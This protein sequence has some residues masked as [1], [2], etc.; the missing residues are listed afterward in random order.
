MQYRIS[1][2]SNVSA[3]SFGDEVI[4]ANFV[5]GVYYSLL[6]PAAQIWEGLVA[7]VPLDRV[8]AEVSALSDAEPAAFAAATTSLV[9]ALLA[10]GLLVEG[11]PAEE[12]A[13]Q[14][15]AG[16]E[17]Q[18]GLP[19][20]ERFTDMEDLLLLDPVHDVEEMGWPHVNPNAAN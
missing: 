7:G 5:R 17:G 3:R 18:Y 10:E 9:E 20:L 11:P 4:A 6:G 13:W 8:V 15:V 12:K 1:P 2:S 16:S 14:A 19:T